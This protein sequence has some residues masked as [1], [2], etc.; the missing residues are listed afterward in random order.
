[1]LLLNGIHKESLEAN[2]WEKDESI[3]LHEKGV[4]DM[5]GNITLHKLW[6]PGKKNA[7]SMVVETITVAQLAEET[8]GGVVEILKLDIDGPEIYTLRGIIALKDSL[9]IKNIIAELTV[10]HWNR[11][12][13]VDDKTVL[14]MFQKYY[15]AGYKMLFVGESEFSGYNKKTMAK[16]RE[17][18]NFFEV[19]L[20]YEIP[21]DFIGEV[22]NMNKKVTKNIFMTKDPA[23]VSKL[24]YSRDSTKEN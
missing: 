16:L 20:S 7:G 4:S 24:D 12:F 21:R 8:P 6:Q 11:I 18:H 3:I 13:G 2:G 22:L 23:I 17:V 1:M 15:D 9:L 19:V 10:S 5:P 14:E